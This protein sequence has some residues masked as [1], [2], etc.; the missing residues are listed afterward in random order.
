MTLFFT[1]VI[2]LHASLRTRNLKNKVVNKI[3][4]IGISRTPMGFFLEVLG[5]TNEIAS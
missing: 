5:A 1:Q 2:F 3:E 4:T